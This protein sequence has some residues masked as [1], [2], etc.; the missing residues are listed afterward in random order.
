MKVIA[1]SPGDSLTR[2]PCG[3]LPIKHAPNH[4][5]IL[6]SPVLWLR[7]RRILLGLLY[8]GDNGA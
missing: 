2:E 5:P 6:P 4:G 3:R 1:L 7:N 8:K